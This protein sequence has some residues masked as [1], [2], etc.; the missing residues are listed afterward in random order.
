L[1]TPGR[2]GDGFRAILRGVDPPS[3]K[4]RR[5]HLFGWGATAVEGL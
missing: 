2:I 1:Q 3:R 5:C 4:L